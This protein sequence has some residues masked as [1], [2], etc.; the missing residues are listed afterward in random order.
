MSGETKRSGGSDP[1][2][3]RESKEERKKEK[4]DRSPRRRRLGDR[5]RSRS[6]SGAAAAVEEDP[7]ATHLPGVD[8]MTKVYRSGATSIT[9]THTWS[10]GHITHTWT[11][12]CNAA[13]HTVLGSRDTGGWVWLFRSLDSTHNNATIKS[14]LVV[15]S[16]S[17]CASPD[18]NQYVD[19]RTVEWRRVPIWRSAFVND[20]EEAYAYVSH[21]LSHDQQH[22]VTVLDAKVQ[23]GSPN[24]HTIT[25]L[26][27]EG[28]EVYR[29]RSENKREV[30]DEKG[31]EPEEKE[32]EEEDGWEDAFSS[33][34]EGSPD[35]SSLPFT[36]GKLH[37]GK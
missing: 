6:P 37:L 5:S 32:E 31:F 33:G 18:F 29:D 23:W 2:D 14:Y 17:P 19:R 16:T 26:F 8:T 1:V 21:R 11:A 20:R 3:V 12:E 30:H 15:T 10:D 9:S 36:L 34:D 22:V 35:P 7:I 13:D 4:R 27:K 24:K 28:I 25:E